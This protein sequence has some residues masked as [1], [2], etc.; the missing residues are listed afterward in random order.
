MAPIECTKASFI[1]WLTP[2]AFQGVC[3]QQIRSRVQ[4]GQGMLIGIDFQI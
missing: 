4:Q 3:G 1:N 2:L